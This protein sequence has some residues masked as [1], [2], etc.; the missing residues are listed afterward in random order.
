M[1]SGSQ[2]K[3]ISAGAALLHPEELRLSRAFRLYSRALTMRCAN[4]GHGD[5]LES[6][7]RFR[8][9]C[10]KCDMRFDRGEEDFF[11]GGMMWNIVMAEGALLIL[12]LLVGLLTWPD[13]PWRALQMT[14]V[15]LMAATPFLFYPLSLSVWL[16]SDIL[17]R[18]VTEEE[19]A[20]H[21]KSGEGEFRKY[22]DR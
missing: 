12:G 21:R 1:N 17:I 13:V 10:L 15:V 19:M 8:T 2:V 11:L 6:W 7:F 18:P 22:R 20:W 4:C 9:K 3:E 14:G 16:A 5:M